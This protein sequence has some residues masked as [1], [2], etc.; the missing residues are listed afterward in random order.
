MHIAPA[1]AACGVAIG[2]R[3]R[4]RLSS[5]TDSG[6]QRVARDTP[7]N[8]PSSRPETLRGLYWDV[9]QLSKRGRRAMG[10]VRAGRRLMQPPR[11]AC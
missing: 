2:D 7:D 6:A 4:H 9:L 10:R 3:R 1:S 11:T 8:E 5:S